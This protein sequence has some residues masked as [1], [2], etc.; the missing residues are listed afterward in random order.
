MVVIEIPIEGRSIGLRSRRNET[1]KKKYVRLDAHIEVD[2]LI[3]IRHAADE[4]WLTQSDVV[5]SII[6]KAVES[7]V[8]ITPMH[9]VVLRD[10]LPPSPGGQS[11]PPTG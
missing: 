1:E 6:R 10:L 7:G 3:A 2:D 8:L 4:M 5:R 11:L 9:R